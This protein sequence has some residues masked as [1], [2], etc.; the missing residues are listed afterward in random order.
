MK[1]SLLFSSR[2]CYAG[3]T[4]ADFTAKAR[5]SEVARTNQ[6]FL[7]A[8]SLLRSFAV[9][10][11]GM[12][13]QN[14]CAAQ[15]QRMRLPG[16][17][18]AAIAPL[19]VLAAC[20]GNSN[21]APPATQPAIMTAPAIQATA[22][23]WLNQPPVASVVSPDYPRLWDACARTMTDDQFEIDRQDRRLGVLMSYPMI[24]KQFFEVWRS[25]A[26]TPIEVLRDSL[27][28]IRRTVR[29]ELVRRP[30]GSYLAS[31]KVLVEQSVHPE[32]RLTAEAQFTGAF[33]SLAESP[34]RTT[35]QGVEVP[36]RYWFALGRDQ[37]MEKQL[38]DS[39]R[40]KLGA[41]AW[42]ISK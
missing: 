9:H 3:A 42:V 14:K 36:T 30:D 13:Q 2:L 17:P 1:T 29:F 38:A 7:R 10:L 26:G 19:L 21:S 39:V 32:R 4:E 16:R 40:N 35:E 31:V 23:Y 11:F 41:M 12:A 34:T 37:P 28:T 22:D 27:Q 33:A 20:A 5:R 8:T 24:S 18:L 15:T 25:D 6:V